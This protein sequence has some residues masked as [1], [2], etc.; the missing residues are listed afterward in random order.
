MRS[1]WDLARLDCRFAWSRDDPSVDALREIVTPD[2]ELHDLSSPHAVRGPA[3]YRRYVAAFRSAIP[4]LTAKVETAVDS[5]DWVFYR[6]TLRGTHR[7]QFMTVPPSGEEV[8]VD[9]SSLV[10]TD[11]ARME[12]AWTPGWRSVARD[13]ARESGVEP[14]PLARGAESGGG[15]GIDPGRFG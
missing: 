4:D 14:P 7:E 5:D 3:G 13:L 12:E 2:F 10:R 8:T 9:L 6:R 15:P 11:G 1:G